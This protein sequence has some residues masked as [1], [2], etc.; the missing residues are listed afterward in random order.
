MPLLTDLQQSVMDYTDSG[1]SARDIASKLGKSV[2]AIYAV[3]KDARKKLGRTD[4]DKVRNYAAQ[5]VPTPK[6]GPDYDAIARSAARI[7]KLKAERDAID[8]ELQTEAEKIQKLAAV[9]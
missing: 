1:H 6:T 2:D 7:K 9:V 3:R 5:V 8:L 4:H